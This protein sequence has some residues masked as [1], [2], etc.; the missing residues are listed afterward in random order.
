MSNVSLLCATLLFQVALATFG[1]QMATTESGEAVILHEDGTWEYAMEAGTKLSNI[2][3]EL[4]GFSYVDSPGVLSLQDSF[5][6]RVQFINNSGRGIRAF[7]GTLVL[8]DLFGDVVLSED[9]R[10]YDPISPQSRLEWSDRI[11]KEMGDQS[12]P[13]LRDLRSADMTVRLE[14]LEIIWSD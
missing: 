10:Q 14:D 9:I 3:S 7:R 5:D 13:I 12:C 6:I 8:R 2:T 1:Q 11:S 4:L